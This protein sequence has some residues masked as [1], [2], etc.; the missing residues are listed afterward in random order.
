MTINSPSEFRGDSWSSCNYCLSTYDGERV[1]ES[2]DL[3]SSQNIIYIVS[4]K[5]T[6]VSIADLVGISY[7]V[8]LG[9]SV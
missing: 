2:A 9:I 7:E 5:Q 8:S 1:V 4:N 6:Q 3:Y